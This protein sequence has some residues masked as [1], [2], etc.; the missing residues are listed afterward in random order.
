MITALEKAKLIQ[1]LQ[2]LGQQLDQRTI[3]MFDAARCKKR[4]YDIFLRC[5]EPIFKKQNLA[6]K[7]RT[8]PEVAA[9]EFAV[10]TLYHLSFRGF[11]IDEYDLENALYLHPHSGWA[12]LFHPNRGWQ[13]WLIPAEN[14]TALI[15]EWTDIEQSYAWLLQEQ[16]LLNCLKTDND[17]KASAA[18]LS[19]DDAEILDPDPTQS[20]LEQ[21]NLSNQILAETLESKASVLKEP[22]NIVTTD[23]SSVEPIPLIENEVDHTVEILKPRP[24]KN[25]MLNSIEA[26]ISELCID[27]THSL[28]PINVESTT[29]FLQ[30]ILHF[31]PNDDWQ[32]RSAYLTE[33]LDLDGKFKT[34]GLLLGAQD[35]EHAEQLIHQIAQS[36][37]HRTI[38]IK[39]ILWAE[40]GMQFTTIESLFDCY[41]HQAELIWQDVSYVPYMPVKLFSTQKY[42]LFEEAIADYSTPILLLQERQ[43]LRVIHGEKRCLLNANEYC[44]PYLI[45]QRDKNLSWQKIHHLI[46]SLPKPISAQDLYSALEQQ[47][48]A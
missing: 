16:Q 46:S 31:I 42:M 33:Q 4:I 38:S 30:V 43:K 6:F 8:Q 34:Y 44:Y 3:S 39:R 15:S 13:T 27:E 41:Q 48:L 10:D 37:N 35:S 25:L 14:R 17:L 24:A 9:Y 11:F 1:E 36:Q 22:K 26:S 7:V 45:L 20:I 18:V 12:F 32:I 47:A 29:D 21:S 5:D 40:L 19:L 28:Y 23:L 2:E